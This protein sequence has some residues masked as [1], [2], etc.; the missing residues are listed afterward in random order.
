MTI[1]INQWW[2]Y[3][4]INGS[5]QVKVFFGEDD[6]ENA[7]ESPF[8]EEVVQPFSA[9]DRDEAIEKATEILQKRRTSAAVST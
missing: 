3:L 6:V 9:R 2:G 1:E 4:H 5:V 8:V 7:R